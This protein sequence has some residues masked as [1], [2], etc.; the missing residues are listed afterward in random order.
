MSVFPSHSYSFFQVD[1]G[2]CGCEA[3]HPML[4]N[5]H[6]LPQMWLSPCKTQELWAEVVKQDLVVAEDR[7]L[8]LQR[9]SSKNT[10]SGRMSLKGGSFGLPECVVCSWVSGLKLLKPPAG[11]PCHV[12]IPLVR[13]CLMVQ[14]SRTQLHLSRW[15][16]YPQHRR[17]LLQHPQPQ[18]QQTSWTSL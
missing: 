13:W 2:T 18:W 1:V 17:Y 14:N 4:R 7:D 16:R 12:A 10:M 6:P 15:S 5:S 11:L 9:S 8:K 3:H